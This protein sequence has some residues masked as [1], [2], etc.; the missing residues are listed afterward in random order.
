MANLLHPRRISLFFQAG[1]CP[2][3]L[4]CLLLG[5]NS[6]SEEGLQIR[7]AMLGCLA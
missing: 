3:A 2:G 6:S 4:F 7:S 1:S 5:L